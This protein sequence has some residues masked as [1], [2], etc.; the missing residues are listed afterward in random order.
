[1]HGNQRAAGALILITCASL[2]FPAGAAEPVDRPLPGQFSPADLDADGVP[3]L[4]RS[5]IEKASALS[6][7]RLGY[8]YGSADPAAGGMDCSGTIFW[9]LKDAGFKDVPRQSDEIYGWIW[10]QSRVYPVVGKNPESFEMGRLRPGDL[11]FW[12]GTYA[13]ERDVPITHVMLYL[14]PRKSD[15]RRLMFGASDGRP[16]QGVSSFGVGVFDFLEP[17]ARKDAVRF[18]GYGAIPGVDAAGH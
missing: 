14:G 15:G 16:Y 18:V 10:R 12:M 4:V 1:M 11:L 8:K 13:V 7:L 3:P 2:T 9:L 5:L 6:G 17:R